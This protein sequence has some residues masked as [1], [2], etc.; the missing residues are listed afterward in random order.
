VD[1]ACQLFSPAAYDA[2]YPKTVRTITE[3]EARPAGA[4]ADKFLHSNFWR[5]IELIVAVAL[6]M[7][8]YVA[9]DDQIALSF[10]HSHQLGHSASTDE[11]KVPEI[12][13]KVPPRSGITDIPLPTAYGVYV[14]SNGK[15]TALDLLPCN[16]PA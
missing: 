6:G 3:Y 8:V 14:L 10:L 12:V 4:R 15:L 16:E 2:D 5:T 9:I 13:S 1:E 11:Q 7:A